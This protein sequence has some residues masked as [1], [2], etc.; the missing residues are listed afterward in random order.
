[1]TH[2]I[3]SPSNDT[4]RVSAN[5]LAEFAFATT[6]AKYAITRDQKFGNPYRAPYYQPAL[7][8]LLRSF[9]DGRYDRAHLHTAIELIENTTPTSPNHRSKLSNNA[10]MLR[11]FLVIAKEAAPPQGEHEVIR[12]NAYV[13]LDG[14]WVSVRPEIITRQKRFFSFTKLRFSKS[15]VS[16]DA[17]E[18][19]LQILIEFGRRQEKDDNTLDIASTR[20]L[21]CFAKSVI[22]GHTLPKLREQQL[23]NALREYQSLWRIVQPPESGLAAA[24]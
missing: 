1:M 4:P 19:I 2:S 17:S 3:Q 18:L 16:A 8:G 22:F 20:L 7:T 21:D 11:H 15:K 12:R 13:E 6:A 23:R 14:V 24:S 9:H 10:A 5:Q